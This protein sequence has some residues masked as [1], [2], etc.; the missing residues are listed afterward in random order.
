MI[1]LFWLSGT[2]FGSTPDG[3][4]QAFGAALDKSRFEFI[5]LR[6]PAAYG[7]VDMP[8]AESVAI[9]K[10]VLTVAIRDALRAGL[11]PVAFG[12]YSQGAGI[13]GDMAVDIDN[14]DVPGILSSQ[15]AAVALIADPKRPE[16]E[17]AYG[18]R[19]PEGYG[20]AGQRRIPDLPVFWASAPG[21]AISAL[22]A[23][24]PL[25]SLADLS[26][27]YSLRSPGDAFVWMERLR[28]RAFQ[29]RWQR[30]WSIENWR[31]WS[32]ALAYATGYLT[33]RHT[34]AYI[35]EGLAVGLAAAVN[36]AVQ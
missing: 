6:Y 32:G 4:S 13:A 19:T 3:I 26:E 16:G 9:G 7:G 35:S 20:I 14:G 2:G 10:R 18:L 27:W 11:G 5:S 36:R 8:Y 28:D 24:N 29:R 15:V 33:G 1:P 22:P 30:W 23:G 31:T 12:G 25:R 21:D 17:G 34:T